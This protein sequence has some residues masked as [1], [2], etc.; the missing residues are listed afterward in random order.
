MD[1]YIEL[2][3][4][5]H[6]YTSISALIQVCMIVSVRMLHLIRTDVFIHTHTCMLIHVRANMH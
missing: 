3:Y 4:I 2:I 6:I 5:D 1:T